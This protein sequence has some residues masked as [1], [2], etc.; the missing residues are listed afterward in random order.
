MIGRA[1]RSAEIDQSRHTVVIE[2]TADG[3]P[4]VTYLGVQLGDVELVTTEA[5]QARIA[6]L[7]GLL[8]QRVWPR[9]ITECIST[10][11]GLLEAVVLQRMAHQMTIDQATTDDILPPI[12]GARLDRWSL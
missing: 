5:V 4:R 1:I 11:V 8:V 9:W 2:V 6:A 10:E 12:D 7:R 3:D